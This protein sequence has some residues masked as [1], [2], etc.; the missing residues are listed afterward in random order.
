MK[1][2]TEDLIFLL[3][4]NLRWNDLAG[5]VSPSLSDDSSPVPEDIFAETVASLVATA[6]WPEMMQFQ[7]QCYSQDTRKWTTVIPLVPD[8][9]LL[10]LTLPAVLGINCSPRTSNVNNT[11]NEIHQCHFGCLYCKIIHLNT[12]WQHTRVLSLLVRFHTLTN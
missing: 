6:I 5:S 9:W 7:K 11:Q 12:I 1:L 4:E 10:L 3:V 2:F 8:H